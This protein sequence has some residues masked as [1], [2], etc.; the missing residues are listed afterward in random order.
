MAAQS[1][2]VHSSFTENAGA[3]AISSAVGKIMPAVFAKIYYSKTDHV[4]RK[5]TKK[6]PFA[7]LSQAKPIPSGCQ[8][9]PVVPVRNTTV[10][11]DAAPACGRSLRLADA[12]CRDSPPAVAQ[13]PMPH[14]MRPGSIPSTVHVELPHDQNARRSARS[15]PLL[16]P[17]SARSQRSNLPKPVAKRLPSGSSRFHPTLAQSRHPNPLYSNPL[18]AMPAVS[19]SVKRT[20]GINQIMGKKYTRRLSRMSIL[21]ALSELSNEDRPST[22]E[23]RAGPVISSAAVSRSMTVLQIPPSRPA[24]P[25]NLPNIQYIQRQQLKARNELVEAA[26]ELKAENTQL[27]SYL[28]DAVS[29]SIVATSQLEQQKKDN[30]VLDEALQALWMLVQPNTGLAHITKTA[31]ICEQVKLLSTGVPSFQKAPNIHNTPSTV[32]LGQKLA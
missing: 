27:S 13:S 8:R 26:N 24:S 14:Q 32:A 18:S 25:V 29:R 12:A 1:R 15:S 3:G 23:L 22:P 7:D 31:Q 19:D 4:P 17:S 21:P 10:E 28:Q 16:S 20:Q 2:S 11:M 30:L 6:R 5:L 9:K